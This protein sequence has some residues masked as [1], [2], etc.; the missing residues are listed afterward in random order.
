MIARFL[1]SLI[2]ASVLL[3]VVYY[4]VP[5]AQIGRGVVA[6]AFILSLMGVTVTRRIFFLTAGAETLNN[7]LFI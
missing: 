5:T 7:F 2:L 1:V 4:V 6:L 3:I